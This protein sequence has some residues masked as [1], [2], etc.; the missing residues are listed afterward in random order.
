MIRPGAT[1]LLAALAGVFALELQRHALANP[2]ALYA[3]GA[4][5]DSGS[6][7][8]EWW[9]LFAYG[10]LHWDAT[11]L[12]ANASL[13]AWLA[14]VVER[15]RGA[16]TLWAVF[17]LAVL[18]SGLGILAKH[19]WWPAPGVSVGASGGAFA[20]LAFGTVLVWRDPRS[21]R[22]AR[23]ALAVVLALGLAVSLLPGVSLLGHLIGLVVGL[24]AAALSPKPLSVGADDLA[25]VDAAR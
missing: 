15:R 14:P 10:F 2:A 22:R 20:L 8:R 21:S 18:A 5:P 16:A 1:L 25:A 7:Q 19:A 9:R 23:I 24:A 11:H 12:L 4:L 3:L 13:L 17:L 6:L